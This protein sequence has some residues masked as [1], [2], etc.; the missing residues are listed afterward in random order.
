MA[1]AIRLR[2]AR[3]RLGIDLD[4]AARRAQRRAHGIVAE[5]AQAPAVVRLLDAQQGPYRPAAV[6]VIGG[7]S[8]LVAVRFDAPADLNISQP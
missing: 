8:A 6:T 4:P 5:G 2:E 7:G 1:W 3:D